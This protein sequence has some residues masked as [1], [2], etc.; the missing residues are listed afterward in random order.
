MICA[1]SQLLGRSARDF[2]ADIEH[3]RFGE[4]GP[5]AASAKAFGL[6][7]KT[8]ARAGVF[9]A[10]DTDPWFGFHLEFPLGQNQELNEASG[11]GVRHHCK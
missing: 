7:T 3:F 2:G 8:R 9:I 1:V 11:F 5:V 4:S 6:A 10:S